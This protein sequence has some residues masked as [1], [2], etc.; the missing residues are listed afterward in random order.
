MGLSLGTACPIHRHA[1]TD[2]F[3]DPALHTSL[4]LTYIEEVLS[5][6]ADEATSKLWRAKGTRLSTFSS[7]SMHAQAHT[8]RSSSYHIS[9][10]LAASYASSSNPSPF[11]TYFEATTP[12]SP[13][14]HARLR[15]ALFLQTSSA[16]DASAAGALLGPHTPLLAPELAIIAS[17][18]RAQLYPFS[19]DHSETKTKRNQIVQ[20]FFFFD[21]AWRRARS[22]LSPRTNRTRPH[23]RRG[24]LHV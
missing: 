24:I 8:D 1:V 20:F 3:Q 18:V 2:T 17:K 4:A 12:A 7:F 10:S 13:S 21:T 14:K 22:A 5:F 6:L 16:Y 23:V 19:C 9:Y 15:T 11:L